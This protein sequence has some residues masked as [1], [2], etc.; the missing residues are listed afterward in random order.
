MS[1]II[2]SDLRPPDVKTFLQ[3]LTPAQA[4]TV[5]GGGLPYIYITNITD[6]TTINGSGY[7]KYGGDNTIEG[8]INSSSFHDNKIN[9]TDF[10]RSNYNMVY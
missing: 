4:E 10:S 3:E 6:E 1:K 5:F 9:T 7:I 2:V 8:G